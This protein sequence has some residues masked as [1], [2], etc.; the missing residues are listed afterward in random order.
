MKLLL[1]WSK[2]ELQKYSID[3]LTLKLKLIDYLRR[4]KGKRRKWRT[5]REEDPY[6][7]ANTRWRSSIWRKAWHRVLSVFFQ[8][9]NLSLSFWQQMNLRWPNSAWLCL[10]NLFR[11]PPSSPPPQ[12]WTPWRTPWSS[13]TPSRFSRSLIFPKQ[14]HSGRKGGES[15]H[16]WS[17]EVKIWVWFCFGLEKG[18]R[19][20]VQM[21]YLLVIFILLLLFCLYRVEELWG[22]NAD[23]QMDPGGKWRRRRSSSSKNKM[24]LSEKI[25]SGFS[26]FGI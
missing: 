26:W 5:K 21:R 11:T 17:R 2:S 24:G 6:P 8:C 18:K 13:P 1:T 15:R 12:P 3:L 20:R 14:S 22:V 25:G 19:N 10:C 9:R 16:D 23:K 7:R 4:R